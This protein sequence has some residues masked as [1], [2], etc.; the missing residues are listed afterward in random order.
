MEP[1]QRFLL[2]G[3]LGGGKGPVS[4]DDRDF[5]GS[6]RAKGLTGIAVSSVNVWANESLLVA[7][8]SVYRAVQPDG[9][10][11]LVEAPKRRMPEV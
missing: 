5:L 2:K 10:P 1:D 4:F 3:P 8:Q 6:L 9:R 11:V 7:V